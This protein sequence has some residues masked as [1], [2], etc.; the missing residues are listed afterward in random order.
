MK[1]PSVDQSCG[2]SGERER[3]GEKEPTRIGEID[4]N[5]SMKNPDIEEINMKNVGTNRETYSKN[6]RGQEKN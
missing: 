5:K 3:G 2:G 6:M 1:R 4:N